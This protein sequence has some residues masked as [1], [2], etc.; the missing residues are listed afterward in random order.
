M[1]YILGNRYVSKVDRENAHLQIIS[2]GQFKSLT[3]IT[4]TCGLFPFRFLPFGSHV[5]SS[6]LQGVIDRMKQELD[7]VPVKLVYVIS[8]HTTEKNVIYEL[9]QYFIK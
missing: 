9:N 8:F 5:S 6:L 7:G 1:K 3:A 2:T 4:I